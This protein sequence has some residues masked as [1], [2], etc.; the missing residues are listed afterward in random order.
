[1]DI[2]GRLPMHGYPMHGHPCIGYPCMEIYEWIHMHGYPKSNEVKKVKVGQV[3]STKATQVRSSKVK[4]GQI[5]SQ[6]LR[7]GLGRSGVG[8]GSVWDRFGEVWSQV[9]SAKVK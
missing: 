4:E 9:R 2:H 5:K 6:C 3:R 8:L 7:G 1:M